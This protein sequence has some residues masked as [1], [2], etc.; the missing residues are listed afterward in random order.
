[1]KNIWYANPEVPLTNICRSLAGTFWSDSKTTRGCLSRWRPNW[2]R[3]TNNKK[4]KK[5]KAPV[6]LPRRLIISFKINANHS[7][8]VTCSLAPHRQYSGQFR[9]CKRI[10]DWSAV[11]FYA[12]AWPFFPH[13]TLCPTWAKAR[14]HVVYP[15]SSCNRSPCPDL[16]SYKSS[17]PS[18]VQG[19]SSF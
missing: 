13:H 14:L 10:R 17:A 15:W 16:F 6:Q 18:S 11:W 2:K 8:T 9:D 3:M 4:K 5:K 19:N 1:M 7:C 12:L